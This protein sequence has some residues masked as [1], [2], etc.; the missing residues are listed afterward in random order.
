MASRVIHGS[1]TRE[2]AKKTSLSGPGLETTAAG[3]A[4]AEGAI[5]PA[6]HACWHESSLAKLFR[7]PC[8]T[9]LFHIMT[10]PFYSPVTSILKLD[11]ILPGSCQQGAK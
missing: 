3:E 1:G 9:S 10:V 11:S 8:S 2:V 7:L 6:M 5:V 4:A